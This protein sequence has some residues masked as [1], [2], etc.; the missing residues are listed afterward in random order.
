VGFSRGIAQISSVK[1][2]DFCLLFFVISA[3][4]FH[5]LVMFVFLLIKFNLFL[6]FLLE[7]E[8]SVLA[9]CLSS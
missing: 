4:I 3:T 7:V 1:C 2:G 9:K 6:K 8:I 5:I